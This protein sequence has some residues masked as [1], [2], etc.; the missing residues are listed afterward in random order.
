MSF[1]KPNCCR[2]EAC[3]FPGVPPFI[4]PHFTS[5]FAVVSF[6]T[7]CPRAQGAL[8]DVSVHR[9]GDTSRLRITISMK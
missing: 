2:G 7:T 4:T 1:I 6:F 3:L 8:L 9:H 5:S